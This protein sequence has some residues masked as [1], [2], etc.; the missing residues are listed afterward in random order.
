MSSENKSVIRMLAEK[1]KE[2][3]TGALTVILLA[4]LVIALILSTGEHELKNLWVVIGI[5]A[6]LLIVISEKKGV[7]V[8]FVIIIIGTL[9]AREEFLLEVAAMVKGESIAANC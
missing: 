1:Q 3:A 7:T 9:V 2:L 6:M 5:S 4:A 8:F